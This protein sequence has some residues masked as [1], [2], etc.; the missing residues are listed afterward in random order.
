MD[1][2]AKVLGRL[3]RIRELERRQ[4]PTPELLAELRELVGEAERWARL[5]GDARARAATL[6]LGA[7]VGRAEATLA[8]PG[9][10]EEVRPAQLI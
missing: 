8:E 7:V 9:A 5:E 10:A 1:E 3:E 6:E 2:A 4:A